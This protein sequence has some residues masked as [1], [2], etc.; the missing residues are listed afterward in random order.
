MDHAL[1]EYTLAYSQL[2]ERAKENEACIAENGLYIGRGNKAPKYTG[3]SIARFLKRPKVAL[4]SS[5]VD[6]LI[7]DVA[8]NLASYFELAKV[9]EATSFPVGRDPSPGADDK[10]LE[11]FALM[12]HRTHFWVSAKRF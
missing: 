1:Y 3:K 7:Q 4:H 12:S 8:G 6:S 5:A 11:D 10:A 9:E 2:L